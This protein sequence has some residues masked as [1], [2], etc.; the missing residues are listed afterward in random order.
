M[1]P[2]A[3]LLHGERLCNHPRC[4]TK[5]AFQPLPFSCSKQQERHCRRK[6]YHLNRQHASHLEPARPMRP[7]LQQFE[8]GSRIRGRCGTAPAT[9]AHGTAC[10]RSRKRAWSRI[11]TARSRI[12]LCNGLVLLKTYLLT[13]IMLAHRPRVSMSPYLFHPLAIVAVVTSKPL[14]TTHAELNNNCKLKL[15]IHPTR[16]FYKTH[17]LDDQ[18]SHQALTLNSFPANLR[19]CLRQLSIMRNQ[20]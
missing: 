5:R 16:L 12:L 11:L 14:A 15:Q 17:C 3:S 9:Y 8:C 4:S 7:G 1:S 13:V 18:Q 19:D 2:D 6:P 20:Q 10:R